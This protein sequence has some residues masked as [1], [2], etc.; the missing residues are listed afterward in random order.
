LKRDYNALILENR[1]LKKAFKEYLFPAIA[2]EILR[3][4]GSLESVDTS[5]TEAA[6]DAFAEPDM[7]IPFS[8]SIEPDSRKLSREEDIM[9]RMAE[10][11]KGN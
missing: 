3:I 9:R 8:K 2:N 6:M 4:E 10:K 1:Y 5:V 7:P 11:I